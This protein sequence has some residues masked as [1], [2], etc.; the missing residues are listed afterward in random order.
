MKQQPLL[1]P[2]RCQ[3]LTSRLCASTR[4]VLEFIDE[5]GRQRHQGRDAL[6]CLAFHEQAL[7]VVAALDFVLEQLPDLQRLI[8]ACRGH[9]DSE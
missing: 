4:E 5:E 9:G 3:E 1:V 8:H 2:D 7:E 6:A